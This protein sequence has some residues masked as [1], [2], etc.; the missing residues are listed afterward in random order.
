M[1]LKKIGF[2]DFSLKPFSNFIRYNT[3]KKCYCFSYH[4]QY[5]SSF[6][7]KREEE[8]HFNMRNYIPSDFYQE[9]FINED[10][11][12]LNVYV[13][14]SYIDAMAFFQLEKAPFSYSLFVIVGSNP[15]FEY[16]ENLK[17]K[18][19]KKTK[20]NFVFPRTLNGKIS[21]IKSALFLLNFKEVKASLENEY[22]HLSFGSKSEKIHIEELSL[23]KVRKVF[24][25][26]IPFKTYKPKNHQ[27][28]FEKLI[29]KNI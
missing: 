19:S 26:A 10:I 2:S 1:L 18:L 14:S 7:L 20:F 6:N 9:I 11:L 12:I 16:F 28:Y 3:E 21:D 13:F 22:I 8:L 15:R 29:D 24:S 4:S 27:R 17:K 23:A 25:M 5:E